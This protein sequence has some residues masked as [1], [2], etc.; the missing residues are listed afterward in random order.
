MMEEEDDND[1]WRQQQF[2]QMFMWS[3]PLVY[4]KLLSKHNRLVVVGFELW[5]N[6][7][8]DYMSVTLCI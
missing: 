3:N 5:T 2:I 7:L 6:F 1:E 4:E 8:L